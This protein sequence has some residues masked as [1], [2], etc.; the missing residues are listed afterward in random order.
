MD[1]TAESIFTQSRELCDDLV[2][3]RET[4]R[5]LLR[6][7]LYALASSSLYGFTM[8]LY[9]P[10]QPMLQATASAAKVP[11]L[12]LLTLAICLPTL[13]FVGLLFGSPLRFGQSLAILMSGI[14]QTSVLLAAFAPISLFF[15]V[16]RS[17]YAFLLVMHVMVFAFCGMA[18][19]LSVHKNFETVRNAVS[20]EPVRTESNHLLKLWMLLYMFVGTQMSYNLSPFINR[21]DGPVTIFNTVGGNFFS[22]LWT[23]IAGSVTW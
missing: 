17:E 21:D 10:E 5:K 18:G 3:R 8:G 2:E 23:V 11:V 13:H 19:L 1:I 20:S 22:Y 12:F 16:S 7:A 9:H 6:L 15:L 4:H 14:C